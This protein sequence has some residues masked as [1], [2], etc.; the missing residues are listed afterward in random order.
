MK[1]FCEVNH[2]D[3][4]LVKCLIFQILKTLNGVCKIN[5]YLLTQ[6]DINYLF[7]IKNI[8]IC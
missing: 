5:Y 6:R 3:E 1:L 4:I 7:N 8:V 2:I